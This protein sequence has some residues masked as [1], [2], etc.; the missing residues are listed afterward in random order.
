MQNH[1]LLSEGQ[2][3]D[4]DFDL[5]VGQGRAHYASFTWDDLD[6]IAPWM[7][8]RIVRRIDGPGLGI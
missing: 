2:H 3:I 4:E 7:K 5:V 6:A 1:E 8:D